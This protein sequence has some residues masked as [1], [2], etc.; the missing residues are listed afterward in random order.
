MEMYIEKTIQTQFGIPTTYHILKSIHIYY[1]DNISHID[2][3]GYISKEVK[4]NGGQA[5]VVNQV[6]VNQT[7]FD[8]ET[9][10]Y[11]AI[12]ETSTFTDGIL[13]E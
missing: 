1:D 13:K 2:V 8:N 4:D 12:L 3:A 10:I 11:N 9:A 7:H 6:Q 5:I